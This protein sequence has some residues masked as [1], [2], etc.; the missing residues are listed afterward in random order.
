MKLNLILKDIKPT[1]SFK[2]EENDGDKSS[3]ALESLGLSQNLQF[4]N[5]GQILHKSV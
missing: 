2:E 3:S 1:R 5:N 4:E